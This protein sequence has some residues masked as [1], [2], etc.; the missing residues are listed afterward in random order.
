V[1]IGSTRDRASNTFIQAYNMTDGTLLWRRVGSLG[2]FNPTV[3]SDKNIMW[4]G[5]D[6][7]L[8]AYDATTGE[9]LWWWENPDQEECGHWSGYD[10]E[11]L[12]H[13][14]W[15]GHSYAL[16]AMTGEVVWDTDH[17]MFY[18]CGCSSVISE[19]S[20]LVYINTKKVR[21]WRI[22]EQEP[23]KTIAMDRDTGEVVW[24]YEHFSS[25]SPAVA[26][27]RLYSVDGGEGIICIAPGPTKTTLDL[28]TKQV[29]A[30]DKILISGQ[31]L[32]QS[33]PSSGNFNAPCTDVPVWLFYCP[34][35]GTEVI[36]IATVNTG[37]AGDFYYEWTV[38]DDVGIHSI[39]ANFAGSDSYLASSSQVNIE[40][41]EAELST[42]E[43]IEQITE[44]TPPPALITTVDFVLIA[45]V[46]VVLVLVVYNTFAIRQQK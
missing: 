10:G 39:I 23:G 18:S 12:Y 21:P 29:K 8:K 42:E 16:D 34:L 17:G 28:S 30:G 11:K 7:T 13:T 6:G 31:L 4:I 37:Y 32:D 41:G 38:P 40:L 5:Q 20:N 46:I 43:L 22:S 33:P 35:G 36:D 2:C 3:D 15:N 25:Y 9:K 1:S 27:G 45:A 19:E 26:D 24:E 44:A 14:F